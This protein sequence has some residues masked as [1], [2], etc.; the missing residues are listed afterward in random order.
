MV[1]DIENSGEMGRLGICEG[2]IAVDLKQIRLRN[3]E[4]M[5]WCW[6]FNLLGLEASHLEIAEYEV[7]FGNCHS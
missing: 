6:E 3:E 1:I 4:E 5:K 2:W 7:V